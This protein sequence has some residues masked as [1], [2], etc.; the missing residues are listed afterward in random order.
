MNCR[1]IDELVP[2]YLDGEVSDEERLALER[3]V[4]SCAQ[5]A[6]SLEASREI[7]ASLVC[8]REVIPS[9]KRAEARFVRAT[10]TGKRRPLLSLIWNAP[11][12]CGLLFVVLG[13][14]LFIRG[15]PLAYGMEIF[16]SR[17]A[18]SLDS[19]GQS[20]ARLL[21][22]IQSLDLAVLVSLC[23]ILTVIPLVA[24]GFAVQRFGRR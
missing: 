13:I 24:F 14:V 5:C 18:D 10:S 15:R 11:V 6:E 2:R 1:D 4:A 7:D 3:H 23:L 8:L 17:L 12:V 9:W 22:G 16:D 19:L 20:I 21:S